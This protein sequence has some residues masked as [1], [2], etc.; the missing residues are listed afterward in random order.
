MLTVEEASAAGLEPMMVA[1]WIT[2][3]VQTELDAVG[4]T[5]LIFET[6]V[7]MIGRTDGGARRVFDR[8]YLV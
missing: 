1:A 6:S 7:R 2:L 5:A 3:L 8:A 4:I